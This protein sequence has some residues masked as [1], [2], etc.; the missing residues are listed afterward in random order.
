M[1]YIFCF[2]IFLWS[3]SSASAADT[4]R[5]FNEGEGPK[6]SVQSG[7]V[8]GGLRLLLRLSGLKGEGM[9]HAMR[10]Y[11]NRE[12]PWT[13]PK[14]YSMTRFPLRHCTAELLHRQNAPRGR[15]VLLLHG[16]AYLLRLGN[17]YRNM[18][19]RYSKMAEDAD[20]LC[21]DYRVA[22]EHVFPAALDD[23]LDAWD[24]LLAYGFAPRDILVVGDS[25][26]GN[27]ALALTLKLRDEGRK[28]PGALVCMSPWTDMT[29][30]GKSHIEKA[31][32]D[33]LF[34][35]TPEYLPPKNGGL[36]SGRPY[37]LSYIG[38][39]DPE[40]PY[41]SP[42]FAQY[43]RFP[44]LLIQVG[45]HE[46]LESDAEIVY[47]RAAV[48]GVDATLTRYYGLFHV[49]QIFGDALPESRNAWKEVRQFIR[50]TF[51]A[52]SQ[53]ARGTAVP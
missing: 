41:L 21:L 39:A 1:K 17:I 44:P 6:L 45:T 47:Q 25:A 30:S 23:A 40:N 37:I 33:L 16:G 2:W 22:P 50:R 4:T 35:Q 8:R 52:A 46:I 7:I 27:L 14:G 15:V 48:A 31:D 53:S 18:A 38:T 10:G 29:G 36:P 26:G 19:V 3:L 51:L 24:W 20:V 13:P 43:G 42:A 9:L 5:Y 28:L 32:V 34:G 49:F 12:V 11:V